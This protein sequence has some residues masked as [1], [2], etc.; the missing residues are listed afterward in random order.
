[1]KWDARQD[2]DIEVVLRFALFPRR[3]RGR[4]IWL[5]RYWEKRRWT[6]TQSWYE[7]FAGWETLDIITKESP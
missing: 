7:T 4:W 3:V 1:M 5:E 2:G 6:V